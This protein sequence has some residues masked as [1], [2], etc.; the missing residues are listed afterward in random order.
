MSVRT[1]VFWLHLLIGLTAGTVIL[2]MSATGVLLTFEPQLVERAE[3]SLWRVT[4]PGPDA[5]RRPL[6]DLIARAQEHRGRER[7]STLSMRRDAGSAVRVGF[8]R[9]ALFVNPY[10]AEVIGPAPRTHDVLHMVEDWHRWLGSRDYGRPIT[11]AANL[12]FLGLA[13][14]GLFIWWPRGWSRPAVR[15]VT[16]PDVRLRG[17]AREFN[18]H[19]AIGFWCAPVLI[20]LTLTAA[21]MSYQWANDLLYRLT[22]NE[23]PPAGGPG[24]GVRASR[25]DGERRRGGEAQPL[26]L[27][28][29]YARAAR[30]TPDWVALTLRL[31]QRPGGPVTAFIQGR[32]TWHPSPRSVLTLDAAAQ[33]VRWE[34]FSEADMGRTLRLLFRVLHTGEVGG[35]IGQ[36]AAGLASAGATVLVW[37]GLSL[38]WRRFRAWNARGRRGAPSAARADSDLAPASRPL[39]SLASQRRDVTVPS[40]P[41]P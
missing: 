27:D 37:T 31:P 9:D 20:V 28:A 32:P 25:P 26:D 30:Q 19:N 10:T 41:T 5:P 34:P 1:V 2:V 4:P 21:V 33:V 17:R 36:L 8:G 38:A 29:V 35:V 39:S 15:A 22:G 16:V 13:V 23:P 11:G 12:A 24:P 3:R 14:S 40:Q 7:A 6:V 18:W